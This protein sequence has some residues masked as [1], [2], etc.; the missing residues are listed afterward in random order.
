MGFSRAQ[1]PEFRALV[2]AAWIAECKREGRAV[3]LKPE[4]DWYERELTLAT[5]HDSTCDCNAGRDY[6]L[7]MAHF[8]ALAGGSIK[9]GMR[10]YS[11]DV[12]RM[13]HELRKDCAEVAIRAAGVNEEY[14]LRALQRGFGTRQPWEVSREDLIVIVGEVKRHVR[15]RLAAG[16]EEPDWTV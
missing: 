11:G 4:R 1:Q 9:W 16:K 14:L 7:A 10:I 3:S 15:R 2:A 13:L 5:G 8:E 12:K 6:D